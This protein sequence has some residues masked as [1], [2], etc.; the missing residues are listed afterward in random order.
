MEDR[1]DR[2]APVGGELQFFDKAE[3]RGKTVMK[4]S[5]WYR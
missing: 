2:E 4:G 1:E 5:G 3:R